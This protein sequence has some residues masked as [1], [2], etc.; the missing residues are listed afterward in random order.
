[1]V[2][3]FQEHVTNNP[4]AIAARWNNEEWSYEALNVEA[5]RIAHLLRSEEYGVTKGQRVAFFMEQSVYPV[6]AA[7]AIVKA[8][9]TYVPLD[10]SFPDHHIA[11]VLRDADVKVLIHDDATCERVVACANDF[12]GKKLDFD[13]DL[14]A[15]ALQSDLDLD[16]VELCGDSSFQIIYTSGSTGKPKGIRTLHRGFIRLSVNSN[17]INITPQTRFANMANYA[18]DASSFEIWSTLLN[19]GTIVVLPRSFALNPKALKGFIVNQKITMMFIT[20]QLFHFVARE[21]PRHLFYSRSSC[22]GR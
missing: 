6:I 4:S 9:G 2:D 17:W 18:F 20:T 8:G 13:M 7:L 10:T 16:D 3:I 21:L 5:N 15:I 19:G 1:V 22:C 11:Y 14:Q 12:N